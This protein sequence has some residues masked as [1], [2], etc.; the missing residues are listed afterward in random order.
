MPIINW[1]LDAFRAAPSDGFL[2]PTVTTPPLSYSLSHSLSSARAP[3]FHPCFPA[4]R[5]R[6]G[7]SGSSTPTKPYATLSFYLDTPEI[8]ARTAG[9]VPA[10][11]KVA[12]KLVNGRSQATVIPLLQALHPRHF[13]PP[14]RAKRSPPPPSLL[15]TLVWKLPSVLAK[16]GGNKFR[17][18]SNEESSFVSE[19]FIHFEILAFR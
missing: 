4:L 7:S 10:W 13:F 18:L 2:F 6:A 1:P 14:Q 5:G 15:E 16:F 11:S 9:V 12:S 8:R 19:I 3:S 17:F